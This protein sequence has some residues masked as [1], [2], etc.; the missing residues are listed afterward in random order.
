MSSSV[1]VILRAIQAVLVIFIMIAL[2][3][4]FRHKKWFKEDGTQLLTK[5]CTGLLIPSMLFSNILSTLTPDLVK[6]AGI[7]LLVPFFSIIIMFMLSSLIARIIK[8]PKNRIGVFQT[9]FSTSNSVLIGFPVTRILFGEIGMLPAMYYYLCNTV[10]FWTVGSYLIQRDG[11]RSGSFFAKENM[12][13]LITPQ[14]GAMLVGM[15]V[16]VTGLALPNFLKTSIDYIGNTSTPFSL[17]LCGLIL[18]RIGFKGIRYEKGM[19]W[20]IAARFII[21]PTVLLLIGRLFQLDNL[22]LQVFIIQMSMPVM[23]QTYVQAEKCGA[24]SNFATVCFSVTS[25]AS[26][27]FTPLYMFLFT[28]M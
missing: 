15:L 18:Y 6:S 17:F 26:L 13:K 7:A 20:I 10:L 8:I 5:I 16:V 28:F 1:D 21:A 25:I 9:M 14:L 12:K 23:T 27:L 4:Y 3:Y 11:G 24:D 2:G 22:T 19:G